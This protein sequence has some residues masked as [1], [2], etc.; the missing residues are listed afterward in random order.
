MQKKISDCSVRMISILCTDA[1][2]EGGNFPKLELWK[3]LSFYL[4]I[5]RTLV[6]LY[7][8]FTSHILHLIIYTLDAP[9]ILC[10][11]PYFLHVVPLAS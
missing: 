2:H 4:T 10:L 11:I 8:P 7:T 6:S 1:I 9:N 3:Y 5:S